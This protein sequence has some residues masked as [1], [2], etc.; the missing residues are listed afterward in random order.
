L[1]DAVVQIP[2]GGTHLSSL[3]ELTGVH[4]T[5]ELETVDGAMELRMRTTAS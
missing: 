3:G 2:C 1:P 4:V 5:L